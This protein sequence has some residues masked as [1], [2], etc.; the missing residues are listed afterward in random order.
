METILQHSHNL[1]RW[2]VLLFGVLSL[3]TGLRGVGGKRN[4]TDGD[5]RT[6]L[7]FMISVD[8][9]LVLGL[10]L[11]F[12]K[13]YYRNFSGGAMGEVMKNSVSRYWTIEHAIGMIIAII[14]VHIGYAGVKGNLPHAS[15]FKR[16]LW[17]SLLA[18]LLIALMAP[19]PFREL[20]IA[21]PWVP[22][23]AV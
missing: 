5:K 14:I 20:G 23:M 2:V 19:W 13:G 12:F 8:L 7:F 17:C 1:L 15:K 21:R 11:Y 9:Q 4:F 6:M 10:L 22:G 16:M 18:L 3:L